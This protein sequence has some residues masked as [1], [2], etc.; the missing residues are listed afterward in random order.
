MV[1]RGSGG[2]QE[3]FRRCGVQVVFRWFSLCSGCSGCSSVQVIKCSV[4]KCSGCSLGFRVQGFLW[5]GQKG[6]REGTE[7]ARI[8]YCVKPDICERA[9]QKWPK[10]W[11]GAQTGTSLVTAFSN[12]SV[13]PL[14]RTVT[15]V[16][17]V[18]GRRPFCGFIFASLGTFEPAPRF[19]ATLGCSI[20]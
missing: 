7:M 9:A 13:R 5:E 4:F 6:D 16:L 15:S 18:P 20:R 10:F 8:H 1:F 2:V 14:T 11:G 19:L 12:N 3:V 17:D